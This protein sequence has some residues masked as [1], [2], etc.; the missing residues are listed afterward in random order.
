MKF[1]YQGGAPYTPFDMAAS[2][3]NY[4]STGN[5]VYDNSKFNTE[6]LG[7][8]HSMDIRLDKKWNYKKWTLDV[9]IDITNF[10]A[11]VQPQYPKFT[12]ART[13]DNSTFQTTDGQSIRND[14]SNAVP[15]IL[16]ETKPV[17]VPTIGFILEF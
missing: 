16:K 11:S 10:Y 5:P 13:I 12:F 14:G 8:F 1:R 4:L 15:L 6:R 17:I 9:Y 3:Q 7:A 2:Q